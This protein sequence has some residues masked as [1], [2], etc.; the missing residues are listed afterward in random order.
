MMDAGVAGYLNKNEKIGSLVTAIR[1][2]ASGRTFFTSE[3]ID[4]AIKW[5]REVGNKWQKLT[6]REREILFLVAQG[7]SN[8]AIADQLGI[9][10]KTVAFH[11]SK[12]L[13][14]I[15]LESRAEATAW[16]RKYFPEDL[17]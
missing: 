9:T 4:R 6:K 13:N 14:Q 1:R 17:E 16:L 10:L 11:V 7:Q 2:A 3:Q 15:D 12:I 5:R 8:K